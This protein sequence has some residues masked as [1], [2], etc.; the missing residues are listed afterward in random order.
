M[1]TDA[2]SNRSEIISTISALRWS[3]AS[4][5]PPSRTVHRSFSS[6]HRVVTS[7]YTDIS[8][9]LDLYRESDKVAFCGRYY[10]FFS[11]GSYPE[12]VEYN[13]YLL[14]WT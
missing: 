6:F 8:G 9:I 3:K 11:L 2:P 1:D 5:R 12:T 7:T 13:I 4:G 10:P 14:S